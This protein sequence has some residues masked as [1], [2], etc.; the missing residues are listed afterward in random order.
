[1]VGHIPAW[2]LLYNSF[3]QLPLSYQMAHDLL[4][5]SSCS[6]P[7][8]NCEI[9]VARD[10]YE[11]S[12]R[13]FWLPKPWPQAINCQHSTLIRLYAQATLSCLFYRSFML[14]FVTHSL[15]SNWR[16]WVNRIRESM[17]CVVQWFH[18]SCTIYS[19]SPHTHVWQH[20]ANNTTWDSPHGDWH[21]CHQHSNFYLQLGKDTVILYGET[22]YLCIIIPRESHSKCVQPI[23]TL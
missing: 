21:L 6:F 7:P 15:S 20:S 1:M 9:C 12:N 17:H 3:D 10:W 22:S 11:R 8:I 16:I 2:P 4:S 5:L 14:I 19:I 23:H 18:L 13:S